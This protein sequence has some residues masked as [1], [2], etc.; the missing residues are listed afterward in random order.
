[1]ATSLT[2][3]AG[4]TFRAL[5][6]TELIRVDEVEILGASYISL[7]DVLGHWQRPSF[8]LAEHSI[9]VFD[10]GRLVAS[11]EVSRSGRAET[12]VSS[13]YRGRGIGSELMR[14]TWAVARA[15]GMTMVGQP[16]PVAHQV[17]VDLLAGNGYRPRWTSWVLSLPEGAAIVPQPLATGYALRQAV[18]GQDDEAAYSTI[19]DAF[20]EWPDRTPAPFEDWAAM[21][22]RRA[23][24]EPWQLQLAVRGHEVVGACHLVLEGTTGWVN[25][26]AVRRGY[27]GL[28]LAR[29]LLVE[30]F[31]QTR[32]RGGRTAELSTDSRTG[33]LGLYLHVGMQVTAEFVHLAKQL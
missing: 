21:A 25:E 15:N 9:G 23:D 2:L 20:N 17:A 8:D 28:G 5:T 26:V 33:A 10:A 16:V 27:R 32:A 31:A 14:W 11:S 24:F 3:P 4:L 12:V 1:M 30:A 22:V 19:E 18:P 7:G 6:A 29:A 13:A